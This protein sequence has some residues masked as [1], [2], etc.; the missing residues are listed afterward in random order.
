LEADPYSSIWIINS[1]LSITLHSISFET[2]IAM[3]ITGLL[4]IASALISGSEVAFFSISPSD[5]HM[6]RTSKSKSCSIALKLLNNPERLLGTILV[7][8]NFVNVGIVI[9]SSYIT[10]SIFD[11]SN[12]AYWIGF[13]VQ[14]VVITF[15]LLLFGEI[16]PK[17]YA[18]HYSLKFS[19]FM[20][21][22]MNFL[23]KVFRPISSFL[24]FST[25]IVK[26]RFHKK[27][28][29]SI[30]DLSSALDLT[31]KGIEEDKKIL[32]GIVEFGNIDVKEIMKSRMDVVAA[33][34]NMKFDE[35]VDLIVENGYSR[36]PIFSE[37]FDNVKGI[38]FIKDL[39][40][41]L[42]KTNNFRWQSL[43][44]PPYFVPEKKKINELL[45]EFQKNKIHIA[46]VVDEY[47]GTSGI[48]T[49]EDVL[50]EIVGDIQDET[51]EEES[52]YKKVNDTTFIF[53]GK[54]LINDFYKIFELNSDIFEDVR[55]DSDTL[56]GLILE[57]KGEIP[58]VDD[59]IK[60]E[61][62][63]FTIAEVDNRRIK[64]IKTTI[65]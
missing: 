5:M 25:S 44:R 13:L 1:I 9:L 3:A 28:N 8:N 43:I 56:A 46:I 7:T 30:D 36:I 15:L 32:K 45:E 39:L 22:P 18:T 10:S 50:E 52:F 27:Q 29:I 49:L 51:D 55:G 19:L 17:V 6:L 62:F 14:V 59:I 20:S 57:I 35:L 24:I 40:A 37:S 61:P 12:T 23:E 34:I 38:L 33:D 65:K 54:T 47:G 16:I 41:H 31:T 2:V 58:N 42:Q 60:Y 4:L 63:E 64:K 11:F 53:E 21:I 48:I 26:N